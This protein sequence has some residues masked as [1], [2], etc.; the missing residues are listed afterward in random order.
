MQ[1]GILMRLVTKPLTKITMA[2]CIG[3]FFPLMALYALGELHKENERLKELD[4]LSFQRI[5]PYKE[6]ME[7]LF[8][9][10]DQQTLLFSNTAVV[11]RLAQSPGEEQIEQQLKAAHREMYELAAANCCDRSIELY[12]RQIGLVT[13]LSTGQ[14]ALVRMEDA[15]WSAYKGMLA[16]KVHWF[17]DDTLTKT[18]GSPIISF[19]RAI[20][21]VGNQPQGLV[22]I[23]FQTSLFEFGHRMP[24]G[25]A[26]W[27]VTP[28]GQWLFNLE[29]GEPESDTHM[30]NTL[31]EQTPA[32]ALMK[33]NGADYGYRLF[34]SPTTGWSFLLRLPTSAFST[35]NPAQWLVY[36]ASLLLMV[37]VGLYVLR[38]FSRIARHVDALVH[39]EEEIEGKL[40]EL[41]PILRQHCL[42]E[43]LY[44]DSLTEETC[45]KKMRECG[46]AFSGHGYLV[47][48][49]RIEN[50]ERFLQYSYWDQSLFR[51][52]ITKVPEEIVEGNNRVLYA[53]DSGQRDVALLFEL[54][55]RE[56]SQPAFVK[57]VLKQLD[58]VLQQYLPFR[59]S[60]AVGNVCLSAASIHVSCQQ[61]LQTLDVQL[62]K[63]NSGIFSYEEQTVESVHS[64]ELYRLRKA[65]EL[66]I[67][68]ALLSRDQALL[69]SALGDLRK[70]LDGLPGQ[71][72]PIVRHIFWELTMFI[73]DRVQETGF[74]PLE[75]LRLTD[76]HDDMEKMESL[77][78]IVQWCYDFSIRLIKELEAGSGAGKVNFVMK[79]MEYVHANFD[80]EISLGGIAEQMGL[81]AAYVSRCFKQE[82]GI[83]FI[84]YLL[85]LRIKHA[86][87]L[88]SKP[89]LTVGEIGEAVGYVN[90][91]SFIRIFKKHE[92]VTPGQY[93]EL[94]HPRSLDLGQVY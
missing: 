74:K 20:P 34:T 91:N 54:G 57:N 66:N 1:K 9:N 47:A 40:K 58:T 26:I 70:E 71:S 45:R 2:L 49:L 77:P 53:Y 84:E 52:F 86:K 61:A 67:G 32:L 10:I 75:E 82:V 80:K 16:D 23:N 93:R 59:V 29:T 48:I 15:A 13:S 87:Y 28:D 72:L 46:M 78:A 14:E 19:I 64:P 92:G 51:F 37:A 60:A 33:D 83:T 4:A 35:A 17:V 76:M 5:S 81:D 3:L 41:L 22:K 88:L 65:T 69:E 90:V 27:A 25:Q 18:A 63:G 62:F 36:A 7:E 94:N 68:K 31:R 55:D 42:Q 6:M 30:I 50:Y 89:D 39:K 11:D 56:D 21:S 38:N 24:E 8:G 79:I 43:L 12:Y 85:T 44:K 73:Y